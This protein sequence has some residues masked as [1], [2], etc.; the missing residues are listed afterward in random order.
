MNRKSKKIDADNGRI[1]L[2][3]RA[4]FKSSITI[5]L[6]AIHG[7]YLLDLIDLCYNFDIML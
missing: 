2:F 6:A 1:N 3:L 7:W 4:N 5:Q